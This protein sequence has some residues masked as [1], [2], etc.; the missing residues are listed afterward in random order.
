GPHH[1]RG[2]RGEEGR[3]ARAHVSGLRVVSLVPSLT[4]TLIALGVPPVAC[5]RFCEQ[6]DLPHVGGTKNPDIDAI[7]AL[8]PDLVFMDRED[9]R[10]EDA[11]ALEARGIEVLPTDVTAV[12]DGEPMFLAVAQRA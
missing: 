12:A 1:A 3:A 4:E 6:P 5:T 11:E 8:A 9:N 10:R 7:V 2:V